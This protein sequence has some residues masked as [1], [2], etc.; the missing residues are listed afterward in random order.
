MNTFEPQQISRAR[1]SDTVVQVLRDS[2]VAGVFVPGQR[3]NMAEVAQKLGLSIAPVRDAL[4]RLEA[5]GLIEVRP[6]SGTFVSA[7]SPV[8]VRETFEIRAALECLALELGAAKA[9]GEY[10][11]G[12]HELVRKMKKTPSAENLHERLNQEFHDLIVEMSG[13]Q[14]LIRMYQKVGAHITIA[15][16]HYRESGWQERL[17]YERNEHRAIV[18][19]I[20]EGD[21]EAA[22][23]LLKAHILAAAERLSSDLTPTAASGMEA[24]ERLP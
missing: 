1:T 13:N 17:A 3:L 8:E 2:I 7:L 14:K 6:R 9:N 18:K 22:K 15:R 16:I 23:T 21:V 19:A 12:L 11:S 10:I 20:E 4:N 5:E 24:K